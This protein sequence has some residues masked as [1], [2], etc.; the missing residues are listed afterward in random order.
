ML[1]DLFWLLYNESMKEHK[2]MKLIKKEMKNLQFSSVQ[3]RESKM[4]F[5]LELELDA[6]RYK[7]MSSAVMQHFTMFKAN[8]QRQ[9]VKCA[10]VSDCSLYTGR[11][12]VIHPMTES[13]YKIYRPAFVQLFRDVINLGSIDTAGKTGGH[14]HV[15]ARSFGNNLIKRER[16]IDRL[17]RWVY[18]NKEDFVKFAMRN[19]VWAIYKP[20]IEHTKGEK[21]SAI[22]ITDKGTIEF[23]FFKGV[24]SIDMLDTNIQFIKLLVKTLTNPAKYLEDH[25]LESLILSNARAHKHVYDHWLSV[26]V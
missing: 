15:S 25:S 17:I 10:V 8:L 9:G 23:R 4:Y 13:A 22:G 14:I 18:D 1:T 11:E 12:L 3:G 24:K 20:N 21:Y 6:E 2:I 7:Y 5:G 19:S 16:N 26:N